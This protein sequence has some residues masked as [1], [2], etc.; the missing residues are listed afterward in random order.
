MRR[1]R[2]GTCT[3]LSADVPGGTYDYFGRLVARH[4]GRHLPGNPTVIAGTCRGATASP[5]R[6]FSHARRRMAPRSARRAL[7]DHGIEEALGTPGVQYKPPGSTDRARDVGELGL[8]SL[9]TTRHYENDP[10]RRHRPDQPTMAGTGAGSP[11]ETYLNSHQVWF[12]WS[13][14]RPMIRCWPWNVARSTALSRPMT[15]CSTPGLAARQHDQLLVQYGER[16]ADLPDISTRSI[17][18]D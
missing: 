8:L 18:A 2:A 9:P 12:A 17:S 7:G 1:S 11:L 10:G 5:R 15:L 4:I 13:T 16:S 3:L 14:P 6:Q